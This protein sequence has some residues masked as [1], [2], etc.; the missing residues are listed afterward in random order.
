VQQPPPP[1]THAIQAVQ[2]T[3][4]PVFQ[5]HTAPAAVAAPDVKFSAANIVGG[6]RQPSYPDQYQDSGR[7]GRVTVDCVIQVDGRPTNC[8]IVSTSGGAAFAS[9]TMQWLTGSNPPRYRPE[10]RGGVP[11]ASEHSWAITFQPAE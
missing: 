8:H 9:A 5:Q 10:S 11:Q 1:Q 2:Q 6:A 4:K 3:A 7:P